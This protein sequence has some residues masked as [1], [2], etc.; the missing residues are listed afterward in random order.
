MVHVAWEPPCISAGRE[1][2]AE[3]TSP[4]DFPAAIGPTDTGWHEVGLQGPP[5]WINDSSDTALVNAASRLDKQPSDG[6]DLVDNNFQNLCYTLNKDGVPI[7]GEKEG[8][9]YESQHEKHMD[10]EIPFRKGELQN[11]YG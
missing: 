1:A 2:T 10:G 6:Q 9:I 11:G 4:R 7:T 5:V 8:A 3:P